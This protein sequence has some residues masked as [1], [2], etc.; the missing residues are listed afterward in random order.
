MN[1][2]STIVGGISKSL[3]VL[4]TEPVL[5]KAAVDREMRF[6][7]VQY[8]CRQRNDF[9][10]CAVSVTYVSTLFGFKPF[11]KFEYFQ[12]LCSTGSV[13]STDSGFS[14]TPVNISQVCDIPV[15]L[16]PMLKYIILTY[17]QTTHDVVKTSD[18]TRIDVI[19]MARARW[20]PSR[21]MASK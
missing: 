17:T 7:T 18:L 20:L 21:R 15:I 8:G 10:N 16:A 1:Y 5:R 3:A 13:D 2:G 6:S 19:T 12:T 4:W 14:I 11:L 9:D